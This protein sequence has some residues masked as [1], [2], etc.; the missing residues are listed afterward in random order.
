[1]GSIPA[2]MVFISPLIYC[3]DDLIIP[4][5]GIM[6]G[7]DI[8]GIDLGSWFVWLFSS[9]VGLSCSRIPLERNEL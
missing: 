5:D 3:S 8:K 1:M 4:C 9:G 2:I 7:N 6:M